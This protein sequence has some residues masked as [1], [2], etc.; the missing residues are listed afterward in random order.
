MTEVPPGRTPEEV[1]PALADQIGSGRLFRAERTR[2][3][4]RTEAATSRAVAGRAPVVE[5]R[6]GGRMNEPK[7]HGAAWSE[8]RGTSDEGLPPQAARQARRRL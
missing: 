7:G 1:R 8:K 6:A 5:L 4:V 3:V 2:I